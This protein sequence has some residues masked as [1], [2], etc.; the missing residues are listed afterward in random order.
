MG[1]TIV[2]INEIFHSIQGEGPTAG[3]P[4]VFVRFQG[5]QLRCSWCDTSGSLD[6]NDQ[7]EELSLADIFT[8]IKH[9]PCK[10][11]VLTGGEPTFQMRTFRMLI[12]LLHSRGYAIE[13]ET[14]GIKPIPNKTLE[15]IQQVTVG[16]KLDNTGTVFGTKWYKRIVD[17]YNRWPQVT[18][19]L[20]ASTSDD[21]R[22]VDEFLIKTEMIPPEKIVL[23]P[24]GSTSEEI[25][26]NGK[27]LV[28]WALLKNLRI[29]TRMQIPWNL[30]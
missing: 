10:R 25:E 9:F 3:T 4:S 19:K 14:N 16:L 21:V 17:H 23:M 12:D 20:V 7:H 11:V 5:C 2:R 13:V 18:Y 15:K 6:P 8:R 29:T 24:L 1:E 28:Q 22:F 27:D 30:R 26:Q